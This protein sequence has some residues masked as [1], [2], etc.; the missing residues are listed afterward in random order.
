MNGVFTEKRQLSFAEMFGYLKDTLRVVFPKVRIGLTFN[1]MSKTV[2]WERDD[3]FHLP[4]DDLA[5][6]VTTELSRHFIVRNDYGLFEY[7]V[8]VYKEPARV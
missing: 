3:L 1:V 4:L 5:A 2:A 8:Y 6:F 7:T